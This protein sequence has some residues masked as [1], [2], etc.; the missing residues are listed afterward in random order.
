MRSNLQDEVGSSLAM[1]YGKP[2]DIWKEILES[3]DVNAVYTNH[4]YE[5]YAKERDEKMNSFLENKI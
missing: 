2:M 3:H 1:Y 4:D 5:P